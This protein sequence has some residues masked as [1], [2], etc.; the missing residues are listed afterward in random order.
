MGKFKDSE[1][2]REI[3]TWFVE[4]DIHQEYLWQIIQIPFLGSYGGDKYAPV[5]AVYAK[6]HLRNTAKKQVS[7]VR[8]TLLDSKG[9]KLKKPQWLVTFS[10]DKLPCEIVDDR[11]VY[12]NFD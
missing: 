10:D 2:E 12:D 6:K 11:W 3:P 7:K 5:E 9:K 4:F 1:I 8:Y